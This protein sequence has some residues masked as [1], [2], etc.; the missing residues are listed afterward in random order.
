MHSKQHGVYKDSDCWGKPSLHSK[1]FW[2]SS[3]R[4]TLQVWKSYLILI[5]HESSR[6]MSWS[7]SSVRLEGTRCGNVNTG[8]RVFSW[9]SDLTRTSFVE[10][11]VFG[12]HPYPG[13]V[14]FSTWLNIADHPFEMI[15]LWGQTSM[16]VVLHS[17][18]KSRLKTFLYG[19]GLV[20]RMC[21]WKNKYM[22]CF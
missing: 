22:T 6:A 9:M 11:W 4:F 20:L 1:Q 5:L 2:K 10:F 8:Q 21:K 19:L 18:L 3:F 15:M 16:A 17:G 12:D 14:L 7:T 13:F